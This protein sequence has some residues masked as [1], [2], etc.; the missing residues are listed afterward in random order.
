MVLMINFHK[1]I[2]KVV[3][4]TNDVKNILDVGIRSPTR[5]ILRIGQI[6]YECVIIKHFTRYMNEN[7]FIPEVSIGLKYYDDNTLEV[8]YE[9]L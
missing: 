3:D 5:S 4:C 7:S 2:F 6:V 1:P 8:A 9:N